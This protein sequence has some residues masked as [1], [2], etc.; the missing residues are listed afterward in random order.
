MLQTVPLA[1][2]TCPEP[3]L[4]CC[5]LQG[6]AGQQRQAPL[7]ASHL[8]SSTRAAQVAHSRRWDQGQRQW[9]CAVKLRLMDSLAPQLRS[10]QGRCNVDRAGRQAIFTGPICRQ[11]SSWLSG[12]EPT[13]RTWRSLQLRPMAKCPS[14]M[15]G[16]EATDDNPIA[17]ARK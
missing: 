8:P 1:G 3:F 13:Q 7:Q 9:G 6:R 4:V 10:P 15:R 12:A 14:L 16:P 5:H 17:L 2:F 11:L